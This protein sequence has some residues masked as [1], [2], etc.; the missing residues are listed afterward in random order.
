MKTKS[1]YAVSV[2]LLVSFLITLPFCEWKFIVAAQTLNKD[3]YDLKE[4]EKAFAA[5][6]VKEGFRDSFIK[7]FADDGIGFGPHPEKTKEV[8]QKTPPPKAPRATIFN[9]QPMF[10]DISLDG[11]LGHTTGPV[12]FTDLPNN[13][14]PRPPRNGMY[15]SVWQKQKD[16]NWRVVVDMGTDTPEAVAP[17][18]VGFT[19]ATVS[20]ISK[21]DTGKFSATDFNQLD[22]KLSAEI[23][24][25]GL[26]KAYNLWLNDEFRVHR[27]G[28]MPI[29]T[30]EALNKFLEN[31][32][33]K[34]S[35]KRHGG[36]ISTSKDLA[37][38]YGSFQ[39]TSSKEN[40]PEGYYVHVWRRDKSGKW[41]LVVDVVNEL[42]T[43]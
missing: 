11:D 42:P 6:A 31:K 27:R 32:N 24:K 37:F 14:N 30:R 40:K 28:F 39:T 3:L 19:A 18:D 38:T 43:Q 12:L 9:W 5:T 4:T 15:F 41:K 13:P 17:I 21:N 23:R 7:F 26:A 33:D 22:E 1:V 16:G 29:L 2:L 25:S 8:L 20:G 34:T 35:F 10:G 36:K